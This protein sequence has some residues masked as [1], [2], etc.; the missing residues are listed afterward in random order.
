MIAFALAASSLVAVVP[1]GANERI[2]RPRR[3]G[4]ARPRRRHEPPRDRT[5]R[6]SPPTTSGTRRSQRCRWTPRA[7]PGSP[8]CRRRRPTCTPTTAPRAIRTS[9]TASPGRWCARAR[10]SRGELPLRV[11]ERPASLPVDRAHAGRRRLGPPRADGRP[12]RVGDVTAVHALRDSTTRTTGPR[13]DR[14]PGREPRG[15]STRTPCARGLHLGRRRGPAHPAGTGQLRRGRFGGDG[16]R[17]SLHRAV[18]A[19]VLPLAGAP[20]GG[21]GERPTVR[22]WA[23]AS[24]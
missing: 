20:R 12:A 8:R 24:A 21:P 13:D 19:A 3:G 7:R 16:P 14:A 22:R 2:T 1:A 11:R 6:R 4:R 15:I 5:V 9:P 18:H 10:P 23:R 17:D